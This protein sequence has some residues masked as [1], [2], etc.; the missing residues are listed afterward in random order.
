M[1]NSVRNKGNRIGTAPMYR[2]ASNFRRNQTAMQNG[3]VSARKAA[4]IP[5]VRSRRNN[6]A[7]P[8]VVS[9]M[10]FSE[11]CSGRSFI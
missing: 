4:A 3:D 1:K 6:D 5:D 2:A 10:D 7:A 11:I 9:M 8:K